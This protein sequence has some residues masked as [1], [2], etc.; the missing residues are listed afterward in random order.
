[1]TL[2]RRLRVVLPVWL[3]LAISLPAAAQVR[4]LTILHTNDLHARLLP[5]ANR[6]GGLA[7]LASILRH[8]TEGCSS[9]LILN[10]GDLVQGSPVSTSYQGLPIYELA[11]LLNFDASVLGNHE[12]DYGWEK[13]SEFLRAARFPTVTANVEDQNGRLLA[14]QAYVIL[15]VNGIRVAIVGALT[16]DLPRL[17][18][19]DLQG[20][21]RVQPVVDTVRR[22]AREVQEKS[23]LIV[24]LGH[25]SEP[26]ENALL[27]EA[28]EVA[29][30]ISGHKH[31]GLDSPKQAGNR[32]AVRAK[33]FGEEIGRLDLEVDVGKKSVARSSW[34]RIPVEAGTLPPAEDVARAV[35]QWENKVTKVVDVPI[36]TAKHS[37]DQAALQP[38]L[39]RAL[40]EQMGTDLAF[41]NL[42][43]IRTF[44]PAGTI[45]ARHVWNIMP[46]DNTIVIGKFRG[47]QLPP[48]ITSRYP[49][50]PDRE[51]TLATFDFV[52]TNQLAELG[53]SGLQFPDQ[54]H[55]LV[56]DVLIDWIKK[57]RIIE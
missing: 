54:T 20:P 47:S 10:G 6:R 55:R 11:N 9:C 5:G 23:D 48:A 29:V 36:G 41:V 17:T 25:L 13:I 49:V 38:L 8:E 14:E 24:V 50:E 33:A 44:L 19:P 57:Q 31:A 56:R 28:P 4:S 26:E 45:L 42:G 37:F 43:G 3:L 12:F 35:A 46:F 32:I 22:Y 15:P 40:A 1:M 51:Y 34:K 18:T 30:V 16:A 2:T 27:R 39:E 7:Q 21:W 53:V 52:A